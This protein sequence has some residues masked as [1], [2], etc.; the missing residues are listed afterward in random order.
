M[1][2]PAR[3]RRLHVTLPQ[4]IVDN[5]RRLRP[6]A[7]GDATLIRDAIAQ[8]VDPS[9][10]ILHFPEPVRAGLEEIARERGQSLERVAVQLLRDA[11]AA[12][13]SSASDVPLQVSLSTFALVR[14]LILLAVDNDTAREAEIVAR[15]HAWSRR[16]IDGESQPS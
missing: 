12:A 16:Q 10:C 11:L 14:H 13:P 1:N 9:S 15:A 5:L 6:E 7:R 3:S 2:A 4:D 8:L